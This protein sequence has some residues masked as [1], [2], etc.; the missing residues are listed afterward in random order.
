[1]GLIRLYKAYTGK[2]SD[3]SG[4]FKCNKPLQPT[5]EY[6]RKHLTKTL[7]VYHTKLKIYEDVDY[8]TWHHIVKH[9]DDKANIIEEMEFSVMHYNGV[10]YQIDVKVH[11]ACPDKVFAE[12]KKALDKNVKDSPTAVS[13][14]AVAP[15][16]QED[17]SQ[18]TIPELVTLLSKA[19]KNFGANITKENFLQ[20][21]NIKTALEDKVEDSTSPAKA[22]YL[23]HLSK[24][25]L[26]IS[27][28]ST[29]YANPAMARSVPTVA[30]T[31]VSQMKAEIAEMQ[32]LEG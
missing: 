2:F 6:V 21:K 12:F 30:G 22:K 27:T 8:R 16:P 17:Y 11:S 20:V 14:P 23:S 31:Y 29:Q 15:A 24:M 9:T 28:L 13:A 1:M 18:K 5:L 25:D 19:V 7:S 32:A 10:V 4:S 3:Y 26:F